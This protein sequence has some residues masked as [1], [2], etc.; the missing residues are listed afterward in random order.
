MTR[1]LVTGAGGLLGRE[2][3][4]RLE[5]DPDNQ[6]TALRHAE[7]DITDADAV[8]S[9]M[10]GHDV[11][12]NA[13]AWTDVDGAERQPDEAWAVNAVAPGILA[14][15][16]QAEGARLV[17]VSTDYVFD[18]D[19][20][21]PYDEY[22]PVHPLSS[23]GTSKAEGERRVL[24]AQPSALVIRTAWVYAAGGPDF[25]SWFVGVARNADGPIPV[26]ADQLGQPTWSR[27]LADRIV[28]AVGVDAMPGIYHAS[29]TGQTTRADQCRA[30]MTLLGYDPALVVDAPPAQPV[31]GRAR[32]PAYSVL[33][34]SRWADARLRP[35]RSWRD[36]LEAA[37]ADGLFAL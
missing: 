27:D 12:V 5:E 14:A 22:A 33:G 29:N 35:L 16:A 20:S 28:A 2:L 7:L 11:V 21:E 13:A 3:V 23:Y 25:V 19:A 32:R 31:A 36:A 18:G 6:V 34:Q 8:R 30:I 15:A 9:A 26:R 24:T 1:W 10:P 17:H 4:R 37:A